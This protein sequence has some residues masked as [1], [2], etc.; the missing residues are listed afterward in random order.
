MIL[1][2]FPIQFILHSL[3]IMICFIQQIQIDIFR[4]QQI[5]MQFWLLYFARL[6]FE[7]VKYPLNT[8]YAQIVVSVLIVDTI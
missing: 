6:S 1:G 4:I 7:T 2:N 3:I 8:T 5:L